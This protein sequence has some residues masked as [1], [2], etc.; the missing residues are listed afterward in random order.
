[1]CYMQLGR[2]RFNYEVIVFMGTKDVC[3]YKCHVW[4]N[5]MTENIVDAIPVHRCTKP[6]HAC[7]TAK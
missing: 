3:F 4:V 5:Q 1:M 6:K 2:I 7:I